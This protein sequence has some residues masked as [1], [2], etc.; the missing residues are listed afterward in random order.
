M[1]EDIPAIIRNKVQG[2]YDFLSDLC[3]AEEL[4]C[5]R[6]LQTSVS[7]IR[8]HLSVATNHLSPTFLQLQRS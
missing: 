7:V 6:P 8:C 1:N 4:N 2:L 5:D 3:M